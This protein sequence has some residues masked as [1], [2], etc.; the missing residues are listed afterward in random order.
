MKICCDKCEKIFEKNC[1]GQVLNVN[2]ITVH[3]MIYSQ[4][5]NLCNDCMKHFYDFLNDKRGV[6]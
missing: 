5:V 6:K 2:K 4:T 1:L 3:H